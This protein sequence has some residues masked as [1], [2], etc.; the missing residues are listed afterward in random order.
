MILRILESEA[1]RTIKYAMIVALPYVQ[2]QY[3][4]IIVFVLIMGLIFR[5]PSNATF[6]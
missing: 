6:F 1:V 5:I 3:Y 2:L 4:S